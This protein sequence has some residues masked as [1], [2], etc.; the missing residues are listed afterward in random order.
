MPSGF[1]KL[2]QIRPMLPV[3]PEAVPREDEFLTVEDLVSS[4]RRSARH[5]LHMALAEMEDL[6]REKQWRAVVDLFAPVSEKHPELV[7]QELDGA[8]REKLAFAL[9]QMGRHDAAIA[10]LLC[11][12]E[13]TPD[14]FQVHSALA[15]NAYNS[16]FAAQN[17]EILLSGKIRR[18]RIALAHRHFAMAQDL[19]PDGVTNFYRQ[20]MLYRKIE[21]K[22][23]PALPL[24]IRAVRNW[25]A[26]GPDEQERRHQERKN[27]IKALYQQA[28]TLVETGKYPAALE[29]LKRCLAEDEQSS[30]LSRLY[31][32]FALGKI[33]YHLHHFTEAR[34][35]LLFAEK[36]RR[37]EPSDFVYELPARVYLSLFMCVR[38]L[39]AFN[40]FNE[41][42]GI[43]NLDTV[44]MF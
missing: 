40:L 26:L 28:S 37:D 44:K 4:L 30:H 32:Y 13:Q 8:V 16:L 23:A 43:D 19:R 7:D 2:A 25:D 18:E 17:R 22:P 14:R 21:N 11:C 39:F 10:E 33:E 12:A 3:A 41:C 42:G 15:Y 1:D 27:F 38:F 34:D 6:I 24:F 9:G 29:A 36:C 20:G 35:A 5:R 31:K